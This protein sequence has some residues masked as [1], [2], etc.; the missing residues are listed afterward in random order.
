M[1]VGHGQNTR[2]AKGAKA[3]T[4]RPSRRRS[5]AQTGQPASSSSRDWPHSQVPR[6]LPLACCS[7]AAGER[8]QRPNTQTPWAK[9]RALNRL[10]LNAVG[11]ICTQTRI[12]VGYYPC[13]AQKSWSTSRCSRTERHLGIHHAS[14]C[15][16]HRKKGHAIP[17]LSGHKGN[18][19]RPFQFDCAVHKGQKVKH[20]HGQ[21]RLGKTRNHQAQQAKRADLQDK[22]DANRHHTH[23]REA[24]GCQ[25]K[26]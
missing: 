10:M 13:S 2:K 21:H 7:A 26:A 15:K 22:G 11:S 3:P 16:N 24:L 12:A 20:N 8:H 6:W 5:C 19:F 18:N 23:H 17:S 14:Y 1:V 25:R 9:G 4:P